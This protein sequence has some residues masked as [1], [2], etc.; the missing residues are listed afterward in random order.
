[1]T[2]T[3]TKKIKNWLNNNSNTLIEIKIQH[4]V[5]DYQAYLE[6]IEEHPDDMGAAYKAT[7]IPAG[8]HPTYTGWLLTTIQGSLTQVLRV[9]KQWV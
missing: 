1:M 8:D 6:Q 4:G 2:T 7:I 3:I 5:V 9:A